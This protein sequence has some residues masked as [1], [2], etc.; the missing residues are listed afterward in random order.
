MSNVTL[1]THV[2]SV[3]LLILLP[4]DLRQGEGG[5]SLRERGVDRSQWREILKGELL[6]DKGEDVLGV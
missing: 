3:E 4:R 2:V 6:E 1:N 5:D